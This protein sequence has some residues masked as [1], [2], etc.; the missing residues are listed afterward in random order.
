MEALTRNVPAAVLN[1]SAI[2]YLQSGRTAEAMELL[3]IALSNLRDQFVEN[4]DPAWEGQCG[5]VPPEEVEDD[6]IMESSHMAE[7]CAKPSCS[8]NVVGCVPIWLQHDASFLTLYDR[9]LLVDTTTPCEDDELLSAVI[10]FNMALLHHSRGLLECGEADYLDRANRLYEIALDILEKQE[11]HNA[12]ILLLM[13][14]L[15]NIAHIDSHLCRLE[16]MKD[17]LEQMRHIL[18]GDDI[19]EEDNSLDE[20]DYA[21]FFMN[22]MFSS[23]QE[24]TVAPAA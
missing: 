5:E 2:A 17:S 15:N 24:F 13:A 11:G 23:E 10:L 21:I 7:Q 6:Q 8:I 20:D 16:D 3:Q 22:S 4:P 14:V 12:N 19:D 18:A 1:N 9:A